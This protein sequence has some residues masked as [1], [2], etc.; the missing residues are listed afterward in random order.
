MFTCSSKHN[1]LAVLLS[2]Q[3][4]R[5]VLNDSL[6]GFF[7]FICTSNLPLKKDIL[8]CC[9]NLEPGGRDESWLRGEL[10]PA[11]SSAEALHLLSDV[12][13]PLRLSRTSP[14]PWPLTTWHSYIKQLTVSGNRNIL[15]SCFLL[16]KE[17]C[18]QGLLPIGGAV[19]HAREDGGAHRHTPRHPT[20]VSHTALHR[21][22]LLWRLSA[23]KTSHQ[24]SVSVR[25]LMVLLVVRA[26]TS[27]SKNNKHSFTERA[28]TPSMSWNY[29]NEQRIKR[30]KCCTKDL[31]IFMRRRG[32]QNLWKDDEPAKAFV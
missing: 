20:S 4:S 12:R 14:D 30:S 10:D 23:G 26:P 3:I 27:H 9:G 1:L 29:G 32:T 21:L 5:T 6:W 19:W 18:I 13:P 16:V 25:W 15:L 8:D 31:N 28:Y 24:L 7:S 2:F 11:I 17:S 22:L